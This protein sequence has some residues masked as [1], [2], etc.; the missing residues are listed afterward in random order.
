MSNEL[1]NAEGSAVQLIEVTC[2]GLILMSTMTSP[3]CLEGYLST[4]NAYCLDCCLVGKIEGQA[5][6]GNPDL[7]GGVGCDEKLY[8]RDG[9][10]RQD[11][12]L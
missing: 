5:V 3:G 7:C 1:P 10:D 2:S 4:P 9:A 11:K 8:R 6:P 12:Q